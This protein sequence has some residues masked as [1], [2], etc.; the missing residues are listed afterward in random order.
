M[1]SR[2]ATRNY[3]KH[4]VSVSAYIT[5]EKNEV[6]MVKTHWRKDTW[7]L[8]GGQV[9]LGEALDKAISREVLE[10]TG[11]E[12]TVLG[13]T[14]VYYNSSREVLTIVFRGISNSIDIAKQSEEIHKAEFIALSQD[15]IGDYITR[16]NGLSRTLDAML[17]EDCVPYETWEAHPYNLLGRIEKKKLS[18]R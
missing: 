5:N 18:V 9:E 3:P 13:I 12:V 11:I 4:I 1:D 17:A 8:P 6:L 14:G 2:Q 15:N 16:P 7:E 10:E